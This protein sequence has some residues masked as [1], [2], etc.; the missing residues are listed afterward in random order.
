MLF[1]NRKNKPGSPDRIVG[2]VTQNPFSKGK[3][4]PG[5]WRNQIGRAHV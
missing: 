2:N 3:F 4:K 1:N 5:G